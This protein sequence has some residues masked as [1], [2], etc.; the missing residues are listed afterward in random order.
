M[1]KSKAYNWAKECQEASTELKGTLT[2]VPILAFP[3]SNKLFTLDTN[4]NYS[5]I[6]AVLSQSDND[7][8]AKVI[9]YASRALSKP[10]RSYWQPDV[11]S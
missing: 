4:A 9:A 1:E 3:D 11:S 2:P 10:K 5:G 8:S 7:G 6:G